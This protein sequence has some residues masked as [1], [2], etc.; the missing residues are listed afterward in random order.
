MRNWP[1]LRA[2]KF[3]KEHPN[4]PEGYRGPGGGYFEVPTRE[5]G[6]LD[7]LRV[8][9]DNGTM[10][11]ATGWEHVSVSLQSR[12]PTWSEMSRIKE[13][14]WR[15]DEC[16]VEYHPPKSSYINLHEFVLHLWRKIDYEFPMPPLD[17]V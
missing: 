14:F 15:D 16:V 8:I 3:R 9:A 5:L 1:N 4:H 12:T 6:R 17:L 7:T 2:E 11:E 10:G 13:L